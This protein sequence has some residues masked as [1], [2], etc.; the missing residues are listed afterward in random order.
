MKTKFTPG[1]WRVQW[2]KHFFEIVSD[3]GQVGDSCSSLFINSCNGDGEKDKEL[4]E[5]NANLMSC[6]PELLQELERSTRALEWWKSHHQIEWDEA[7]EEQ[8][9]NNKK[10][11]A[12]ARGQ[13]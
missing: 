3:Q 9:V 7:D 4:A 2:N 12:K 10:I 5:A 11:L 6:S 13:S 1:P 8:L